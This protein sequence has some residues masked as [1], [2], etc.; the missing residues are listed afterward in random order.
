MEFVAIHRYGRLLI[1]AA[2]SL[3]VKRVKSADI[4]VDDTS[5]IMMD[6]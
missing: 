1:P 5:Q 4:S 2:E 3:F 6:I